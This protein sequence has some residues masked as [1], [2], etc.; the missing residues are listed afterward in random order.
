MQV[1]A[2]LRASE[3]AFDHSRLVDFSEQIQYDAPAVQLTPLVQEG[4]RLVVT[5][6]RLYF[7]PLHN[8]AGGNPVRS[9][10]LAALA[11]VAHRNS[12]LRPV[13]EPRY[14]PHP[15]MQAALHK[16]SFSTLLDTQICLGWIMLRDF[17]LRLWPLHNACSYPTPQWRF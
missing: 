4:G 7:Q 13:G 8:V 2:R 11:A 1:G 10:P 14:L 17:A 16:Y 12:S 9:H 3:A 5:D 6:H 15:I